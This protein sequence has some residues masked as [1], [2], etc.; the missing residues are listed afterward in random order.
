[1][2][3]NRQKQKKLASGSVRP[4]K[5]KQVANCLQKCL[6]AVWI[7]YCSGCHI[8]NRAN[9][10]SKPYNFFPRIVVFH[11]GSHSYKFMSL[12]LENIN[13]ASRVATHPV[14]NISLGFPFCQKGYD[15]SLAPRPRDFLSLFSINRVS[16][17]GKQ[18]ADSGGDY[19]DE[20]S[21]P[22]GDKR[23]W[24]AF[25]AHGFLFVVGAACGTLL[26]CSV[27][28]IAERLLHSKSKF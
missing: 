8:S 26:Y 11:P 9:E 22:E 17:Q 10:C 20:G 5:R 4:D 19:C 23:I 14:S 27:V 18:M 25:A 28:V 16:P 15:L 7:V 13:H 2:N 12:G 6:L 24:W 3:K 1:M 21:A